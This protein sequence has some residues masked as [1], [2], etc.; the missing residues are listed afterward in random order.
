M[1][2]LPLMMSLTYRKTW[3]KCSSTSR[4]WRLSLRKKSIR[5]L[6]I[7][8]LLCMWWPSMLLTRR[9]GREMALVAKYIDE[10]MV[11]LE[12][13]YGADHPTLNKLIP[14]LTAIK[15]NEK[16]QAEKIWKLIWF[17]LLLSIITLGVALKIILAPYFCSW[18]YFREQPDIHFID[19]VY[20]MYIIR[21]VISYS[22]AFILECVY[23]FNQSLTAIKGLDLASRARVN[24]A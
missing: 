19:E 5:F 11:A 17:L 15:E 14:I 12:K 13:E 22:V 10:A 24:A 23:R 3:A 20:K 4:R 16:N 8:R 2:L 21:K 7:T 18:C 9:Y 6:L 1:V